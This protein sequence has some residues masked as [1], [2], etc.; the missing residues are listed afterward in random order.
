MSLSEVAEG[1]SPD[2]PSA[3]IKEDNHKRQ[4]EMGIQFNNHSHPK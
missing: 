3:K 2:L 4:N 1:H